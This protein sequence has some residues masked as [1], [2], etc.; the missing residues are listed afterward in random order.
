MGNEVQITLPGSMR[1]SEKCSQ[2]DVGFIWVQPDSVLIYACH[3]FDVCSTT[4]STFLNLVRKEEQ[5]TEKMQA[6][7]Q[8]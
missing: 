3:L 7:F 6:I 8:R 1:N 2:L 4:L 5:L